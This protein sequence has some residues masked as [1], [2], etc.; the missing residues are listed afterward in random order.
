V[1]YIDD[2]DRCPPRR[3]VEVLEAVHLLL[4]FPL[5]VVVVGVDSRWVLRSLESHYWQ[6]LAPG[7]A[8]EAPAATPLDYVEKIFQVPYQLRPLDAPTTRRML[9][10]LLEEAGIARSEDE[11]AVRSGTTPSRPAQAGSRADGARGVQG[12]YAGGP[13][14]IEVAAA[15]PRDMTPYSLHLE[16]KERRAMAELA[17]LI[18]TTPRTVKRFAN[19]YR[20]LKVRALE[21]GEH[22]L[23]GQGPWADYEI[24]LFLLAVSTGLPDLARPL[25]HALT[26]ARGPTVADVL[27][28]LVGDDGDD[29]EQRR[30]LH[31]WFQD[32]EGRRWAKL[33][34]GRCKAWIV[35]DV[36]RFS[37]IIDSARQAI[38]D[39]LPEEAAPRPAASEP[40]HLR[41]R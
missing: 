12:Q 35:D 2:L 26:T 40:A 18:G 39:E 38:G 23:D 29:L 8:G 36:R 33:P 34:A 5:F 10:G 19:L 31:S 22:L 41:L 1:L 3:V 27:G 20:I 16:S 9:H 28:N 15:P 6:L 32:R 21:R 4:A 24:L 30:Q 17:G 25:F 37:F 7:D 11:P 13:V 14:A